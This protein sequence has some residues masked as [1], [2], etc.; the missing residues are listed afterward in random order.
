MLCLRSDGTVSDEVL[1]RL[2]HELDVKV[3]PSVSGS[4]D[5]NREVSH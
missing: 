1:H 3:L 5:S 4:G 2:E